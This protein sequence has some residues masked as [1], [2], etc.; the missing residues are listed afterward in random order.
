MVVSM[1]LSERNAATLREAARVLRED[2]CAALVLRFLRA[3]QLTP[4]ELCRV[5]SIATRWRPRTVY[6]ALNT[7]RLVGLA[8]PTGQKASR[9]GVVA[10]L[11]RAI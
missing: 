9:L 5:R 4:V 1:E 3:E 2:A 8:E 11:W 6:A 10:E 7:L